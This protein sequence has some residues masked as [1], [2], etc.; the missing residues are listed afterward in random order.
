[1][2]ETEDTMMASRRSKSERV[3]ERRSLSNLLV[4]GRFFFDIQV[5][6]R[7]VRLG[8][9]VVVVGDE[10][11]DRVSREELLEFVKELR[12]KGFIVSQ[13]QSGSV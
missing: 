10:I 6:G 3:A 8:L 12:G 7:N 9:V 13:D 2:H 4:D 1:M 5:S 11:L